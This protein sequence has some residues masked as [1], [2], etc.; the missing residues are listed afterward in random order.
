MLGLFKM[1]PLLIGMLLAS[2][3]VATW[4]QQNREPA[5]LT[6][7]D[8]RLKNHIKTEAIRIPVEVLAKGSA[9]EWIYVDIPSQ[10]AR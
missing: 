8:Q 10:D 2:P 3:L 6:T 7:H 4:L 5:I 9:G 1:K